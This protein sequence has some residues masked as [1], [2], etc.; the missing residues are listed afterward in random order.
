MLTSFNPT[1]YRLLRVMRERNET[2]SY[3]ALS[4]TLGRDAGQVPDRQITAGA[5]ESLGGPLMNL[6]P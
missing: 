2:W 1:L 3:N 6:I 5:R 4:M